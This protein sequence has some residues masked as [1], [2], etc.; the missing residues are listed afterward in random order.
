[1]YKTGRYLLRLK[2]SS[3]AAST[4]AKFFHKINTDKINKLVSNS[5]SEENVP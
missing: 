5:D 4:M 2:I 1:M 3:F